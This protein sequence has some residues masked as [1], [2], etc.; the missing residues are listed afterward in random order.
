MVCL[1]SLGVYE[2]P[3]HYSNYHML[4]G[5]CHVDKIEVH[6]PDHTGIHK[7]YLFLIKSKNYF[8]S[9]RKGRETALLHSF[10]FCLFSQQMSK[11]K[12]QPMCWM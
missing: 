11:L 10:V 8:G 2:L 3:V 7:H 4:T 9:W 6:T 5:S 12:Q 1:D